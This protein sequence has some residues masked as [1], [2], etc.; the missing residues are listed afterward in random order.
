M[1][2]ADVSLSL[3]AVPD[4]PSTFETVCVR[5]VTDHFSAIVVVVYRPGSVAVLQSFHDELAAVL[6]RV[7]IN[8]EPIFRRR[9]RQHSF[10]P[11][12]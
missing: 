3:I 11:R 8:Q 2:S 4:H 10:G 9:R 6:D 1:A 7:A 12:R 5:A